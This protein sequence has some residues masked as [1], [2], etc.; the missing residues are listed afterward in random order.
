MNEQELSFAIGGRPER[1]SALLVRPPGAKALYVMGH[2][3]G[4]DMRHPFMATFAQLL[5]ERGIATLRYNFRYMEIGRRL[6]DPLAILED[7]VRSAVAQAAAAARDLTLLAGGKSMGG[8]MT[9]LAA[10]KT[11]LAGV[12]GLVFL[13]FPL[14]P[15]NKP[16]DSRSRHLKDVDPPM[17]FLQG[18]RDKLADLDLLIPV[19]DKLGPGAKLHVIE[20]GDHSFKVLKHSDRTADEVMAELVETMTAWIEAPQL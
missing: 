13:G 18:T 14:H 9:S 11:P 2:G 17:L 1:V 12:R 7:T 8:R 6:P 3:A 5:A 10:S 16:G 15:A 20:G 4:A 19:I